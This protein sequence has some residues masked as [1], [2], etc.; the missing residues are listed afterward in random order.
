MQPAVEWP[1][2][3]M[4]RQSTGSFARAASIVAAQRREHVGGAHGQRTDAFAGRVV[5]RVGDGC[6]RSHVGGLGDAASVGGGLAAELFDDVYVDPWR[7]AR[8]DD[9]VLIDVGV[10]VYAA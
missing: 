3:S 10:E 6:G 4:R 9:L 8:A 2:R 7:F 1:L 5:E